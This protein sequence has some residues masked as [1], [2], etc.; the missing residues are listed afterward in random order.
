MIGRLLWLGVGGVVALIIVCLVM[1]AGKVSVDD[2]SPK[3][4]ILKVFAQQVQPAFAQDTVIREEHVYICGD[5]DE[6]ARNTAAA[7]KINSEN[8]LKEKYVS[9]G[10]ALEMRN[11]EVLA[12]RKVAEFCSYHRNFRH[13]GIRDDKLAIYQ[14]PLGYEQKLLKVE[15]NF[16][17]NSLSAAL[18]VKLQQ[19][20]NLFQMTPETQAKLRYE[21]EF[22]N[23]DALNAV[24]ENL[25]EMQEE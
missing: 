13:L 16:P 7:L 10:Y 8:E 3:F 6:V 15:D 18:Q 12:K 14:G 11:N 25:D 2:S 5:I 24:L 22:A 4:A 9:L 1:L 17:I 20:I 19:S 23:E 21:L